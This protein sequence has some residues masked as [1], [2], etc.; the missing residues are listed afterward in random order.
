MSSLWK[1]P[2]L[3]PRQ[4]ELTWLNLFHTTHDQ[5]CF[6][7]DP[8]LHFL[9]L[10]NKDSNFKKPLKD[11]CNIKCLLTGPSTTTEDGEDQDIEDGGFLEGELDRLFTEE[12]GEKEDTASTR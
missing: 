3:S 9:Q 7:K 4:Q 12:N 8:L 10:I 6:C 2:N 1:M 11:I 5:F